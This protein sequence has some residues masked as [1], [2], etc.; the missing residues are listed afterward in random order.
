MGLATTEKLWFMS[1][2]PRANPLETRRD[3][4][5]LSYQKIADELKQ[6]FNTE[7]SKQTVRSWL[8]GLYAPKNDEIWTQ[9]QM[10]IFEREGALKSQAEK[11]ST[12][13]QSP[14]VKETPVY[15]NTNLD[16]ARGVSL[17]DIGRH[18]MNLISVNVYPIKANSSWSAKSETVIFRLSALLGAASV[19]V[20]VEKEYENL[21]PGAVVS[22]SPTD[23]AEHGLYLV[24]RANLDDPNSDY[25]FGW[26]KPTQPTSIQGIDNEVYNLSDWRVIGYAMAVSYGPGVD[27]RS[28]R[29]EMDGYGPMSRA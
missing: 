6:R 12:L 20:V 1:M 2:D 19:H 29:L 13:V 3:G 5:G 4:I 26:I 14:V 9:L 15:Y 24:F 23:Y 17:T 27:K 8:H 28:V 25:L 22:F 18:A 21:R 11:F 16:S 7:A 10:I